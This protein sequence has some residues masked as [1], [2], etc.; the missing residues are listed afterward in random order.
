MALED[1]VYNPLS[2]TPLDKKVKVKKEADPLSSFAQDQLNQVIPTVSSIVNPVQEIAK[3]A[4]IE[5]PQSNVIQV[6]SPV[7]QSQWIPW[8]DFPSNNLMSMW[9]PWV[10]FDLTDD[11]EIQQIK[12]LPFENIL[13]DLEIYKT[14]PTYKDIIP[15]IQDESKLQPS[16]APLQTTVAWAWSVAWISQPDLATPF[17]VQK[18]ID[19]INK[20]DT[21]PTARDVQKQ[22]LSWL[23]E[24]NDFTS[25]AIWAGLYEWWKLLNKTASNFEYDFS[26]N[27]LLRFDKHIDDVMNGLLKGAISSLWSVAQ[28][29]WRIADKSWT[30][31]IIDEY[32]NKSS[33]SYETIIENNKKNIELADK[34]LELDWLELLK[35][36]GVQNIDSLSEPWKQEYKSLVNSYQKKIDDNMYNVW[37][38]LWRFAMTEEWQNTAS[39]VKDYINIW[40]TIFSFAAWWAIWGKAINGLLKWSLNT[41]SKILWLWLAWSSNIPLQLAEWFYP[42]WNSYDAVNTNKFDKNLNTND[43]VS[44]ITAISNFESVDAETQNFFLNKIN[45]I[46]KNNWYTWKEVNRDNIWDYAWDAFKSSEREYANAQTLALQYQSEWWL[47]RL[48]RQNEEKKFSNDNKSISQIEWKIKDIS[49]WDQSNQISDLQYHKSNRETNN[50]FRIF[51]SDKEINISNIIKYVS[52]SD[53]GAVDTARLI[54]QTWKEV[55]GIEWLSD[56]DKNTITKIATNKVNETLSE[57]DA[58]KNRA[59]KKASTE[60]V[61]LSWEEWEEWF[62]KIYDNEKANSSKLKEINN[63]LWW[64]STINS[65]NQIAQNYWDVWFIVNPVSYGI[66]KLEGKVWSAVFWS[67]VEFRTNQWYWASAIRQSEVLLSGLAEYIVGALLWKAV[68]KWKVKW[69]L[70]SEIKNNIDNLSAKNIIKNAWFEWLEEWVQNLSSTTLLWDSTTPLTTS[71]ILWDTLVSMWMWSLMSA[72]NSLQQYLYRQWIKEPN[73][74]SAKLSNENLTPDQINELLKTKEQK[75]QGSYTSVQKENVWW[76][77]IGKKQKVDLQT[78]IWQALDNP[79]SYTITINSKLANDNNTNYSFLKWE[80]G[81]YKEWNNTVIV[82]Q[83]NPDIKYNMNKN[84]KWNYVIQTIAQNEQDPIYTKEIALDDITTNKLDQWI[85]VSE[86]R[87]KWFDVISKFKSNPSIQNTEFDSYE[88]TW[89]EKSWRRWLIIKLNDEQKGLLWYDTIEWI[90]EP[91]LKWYKPEWSLTL[92]YEDRQQVDSGIEN[93][94]AEIWQSVAIYDKAQKIWYIMITDYN[95]NEWK[96]FNTTN[97]KSVEYVKKTFNEKMKNWHWWNAKN[98]FV[99]EDSQ[100]VIENWKWVKWYYDYTNKKIVLRK[101]ADYTTIIHEVAHAYLDMFVANDKSWINKFEQIKQW[102]NAGKEESKKYIKWFKEF[103]YESNSGNLWEDTKELHEAFARHFEWYTFVV[104]KKELWDKYPQ[105]ILWSLVQE[106][107]NFF[108]L[109]A[110][111]WARISKF[112]VQPLTA[113]VKEIF[114]DILLNKINKKTN[115]SVNDNTNNVV[116]TNKQEL[117]NFSKIEQKEHEVKQYISAMKKKYNKWRSYKFDYYSAWFIDN[118]Y[119]EKDNPIEFKLLNNILNL[120]QNNQSDKKKEDYLTKQERQKTYKSFYHA[121]ELWLD[122]NYRRW[123]EYYFWWKQISKEWGEVSLVWVYSQWDKYYNLYKFKTKNK[124]EESEDYVVIEFKRTKKDW[125][126]QNKNLT[127]YVIKKDNYNINKSDIIISNN[128]NLSLVDYEFE[129]GSLVKEPKNIKVKSYIN[130]AQVEDKLIT[131]QGMHFTYNDMSHR[132]TIKKIKWKTKETENYRIALDIDKN[133]WLYYIPLKNFDDDDNKSFQIIND[134]LKEWSEYQQYLLSKNEWTEKSDTT[135]N[136]EK[137]KEFVNDWIDYLNF[138]KE[139]RKIQK[140]VE[141]EMI[142]FQEE[143]KLSSDNKQYVPEDSLKSNPIFNGINVEFVKNMKKK[144]NDKQKI[145]ARMISKTDNSWNTKYTLKIDIPFLQEKFKE[146]SWIKPYQQEDGSSAEELPYNIF[147][148]FDNFLTF[149]LLHEYSHTFLPQFRWE[150]KWDYETRI[151]Y[152]ALNLIS[153]EYDSN[154]IYKYWTDNEQTK[155]DIWITDNKNIDSIQNTIDLISDNQH[156]DREAIEKVVEMAQ[157]EPWHDALKNNAIAMKHMIGNIFW[158]EKNVYDLFLLTYFNNL[159]VAWKLKSLDKAVISDNHKRINLWKLIIKSLWYRPIY[160]ADKI[161]D[162]LKL[163]PEWKDAIAQYADHFAIDEDIIHNSRERLA[164][165]MIDNNI[166]PMLFNDLY[167]IVS[168]IKEDLALTDF[169]KEDL[170]QISAVSQVINEAVGVT[171]EPWTKEYVTRYIWNKDEASGHYEKLLEMEQNISEYDKK[172]Q[173]AIINDLRVYQAYLLINDQAIDTNLKYGLLSMFDYKQYLEFLDWFTYTQRIYMNSVL[174]RYMKENE[175]KDNRVS[176]KEYLNSI[177]DKPWSNSYLSGIYDDL[178]LKKFS[179]RKQLLID[180]FS[181]FIQWDEWF[182]VLKDFFLQKTNPF[183]DA[184][185]ESLETLLLKEQIKYWK[186]KSQSNSLYNSIMNFYKS[187]NTGNENPTYE[188]LYYTTKSVLNSDWMKKFKNTMNMFIKAYE[189]NEAIWKEEIELYDDIQWTTN[190]ENML[191]YLLSNFLVERLPENTWYVWNKNV[192]KWAYNYNTTVSHNSYM[193]MET[194]VWNEI[195]KKS[196]YTFS[197]PLWEAPTTQYKNSNT[198]TFKSYWDKELNQEWQW[199]LAYT[200]PWITI[201]KDEWGTMYVNIDINDEWAFDIP[202]NNV[203]IFNAWMEAYFS[204]LEQNYSVNSYGNVKNRVLTNAIKHNAKFTKWDYELSDNFFQVSSNFNKKTEDIVNE[205]VSRTK[206]YIASL[207]VNG[208]IKSASGVYWSKSWIVSFHDW[209]S[210]DTINVDNMK[211]KIFWKQA[212]NILYTY[213]FINQQ[214]SDIQ[215]EAII[216]SINWVSKSKSS[217]LNWLL[218]NMTSGNNE[219]ELWLKAIEVLKYIKADSIVTI[220]TDKDWINLIDDWYTILNVINKLQNVE[221][222]DAVL[223]KSFYNQIAWILW[224]IKDKNTFSQLNYYLHWYFPDE[225]FKINENNKN[226]IANLKIKIEDFKSQIDVLNNRIISK[227]NKNK[228]EKESIKSMKSEIT[229][230]EKEIKDLQYTINNINNNKED[231]QNKEWTKFIQW[232]QDNFENI[233]NIAWILNSIWSSINTDVLDKIISSYTDIRSDLNIRSIDDTDTTRNTLY[234]KMSLWKKLWFN[235][236]DDTEFLNAVLWKNNILDSINDPTSFSTFTKS[237]EPWDKVLNIILNSIVFNNEFAQYKWYN[238]SWYKNAIRV[239]YSYLFWHW[240]NTLN[241]SVSFTDK[242]YNKDIIEDVD[243]FI[244]EAKELYK[245]NKIAARSLIWMIWFKWA[246]GWEKSTIDFTGLKNAIIDLLAK[247]QEDA[248]NSIVD[249]KN[250]NLIKFFGSLVKNFKN[251]NYVSN[252]T[253]LSNASKLANDYIKNNINQI[254]GSIELNEAQERAVDK[255]NTIINWMLDAKFWNDKKTKVKWKKQKNWKTDVVKPN[256]NINS[257]FLVIHWPANTW[258]TTLI[259][260]I[261]D[262]LPWGWKVSYFVWAKNNVTKN[263]LEKELEV[264]AT[265]VFDMLYSWTLKNKQVKVYTDETKKKEINTKKYKDKK[266]NIDYEKISENNTTNFTQKTTYQDWDWKISWKKL[267]DSEINVLIIDEAQGVDQDELELFKKLYKKNAIIVMLWDPMQPIV[268]NKNEYFNSL[269]KKED[270]NSDL[271]ETNFS[272]LDQINFDIDK[273]NL[274]IFLTNFFMRQTNFWKDVWTLKK[275]PILAWSEYSIENQDAIQFIPLNSVEEQQNISADIIAKATDKS[276]V[277]PTDAYLLTYKN[278]TRILMNDLIRAK[279]FWDN[280]PDVREWDIMMYLNSDKDWEKF[281]V[282]KRFIVDSKPVKM[283]DEEV[284]KNKPLSKLLDELENKEAKVYLYNGKPHIFVK[285]E[286]L[287]YWGL[288]NTDFPIIS[289]WYALTSD[290]ALWTRAWTVVVYNDFNEWLWGQDTIEKERVY[291]AITRTRLNGRLYIADA[292]WYVKYWIKWKKNELAIEDSIVTEFSVKENNI[293]LPMYVRWSIVDKMVQWFWYIIDG[294]D[295]LKDEKINLQKMFQTFIQEFSNT[296]PYDQSS[297]DQEVE[298]I[299]TTFKSFFAPESNI[300]NILSYDGITTTQV[301]DIINRYNKIVVDKYNDIK[302]ASIYN[303]RQ[304]QWE[305]SSDYL[306]IYDTDSKELKWSRI[307][308]NVWQDNDKYFLTKIE[309]I[310]PVQLDIFAK[311][312]ESIDE[313]LDLLLSAEDYVAIQY[314][315]KDKSNV[316]QKKINQYI[317]YLNRVLQDNRKKFKDTEEEQTRKLKENTEASKNL[318]SIVIMFKWQDNI[319]FNNL[320]RFSW[321]EDGIKN[322]I[323]FMNNLLVNAKTLE[324]QPKKAIV[325]DNKDNYFVKL[326]DKF[327][328]NN[329][330]DILIAEIYDILYSK[331]EVEWD[332]I[333]RNELY[334]SLND[335]LF[336][337]Y[338]IEWKNYSDIVVYALFKYQKLWGSADVVINSIFKKWDNKKRIYTTIAEKRNIRL[339]LKKN[340]EDI[341]ST[342]NMK[343]INSLDVIRQSKINA[344][345]TVQKLE[346]SNC[347]ALS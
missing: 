68:W 255:F 239:W 137:L 229:N 198:I 304:D 338:I 267:S 153:L 140:E 270:K 344:Q 236:D 204:F 332:K 150:T 249:G 46:N 285:S 99:E 222:S 40:W 88:Q 135:N 41:A 54:Q 112:K 25:D 306:D 250:Y 91:N 326:I 262:N 231:D 37:E 245:T 274:D 5:L 92:R 130:G 242:E 200:I 23:K 343:K 151:N 119:N 314:E 131:L 167:T 183:I 292:D 172:S 280:T 182:N 155:E 152:N 340:K 180:R 233:K 187:L 61:W 8:I 256:K 319:D 264:K 320:Y 224:L 98:Y 170:W 227:R 339:A 281:S 202:K 104:A 173:L 133:N 60:L 337:Q 76:T 124:S 32:Q 50:K 141:E 6:E 113:W 179:N 217:R 118:L 146:K 341:T 57:I 51:L 36:Y 27:E 58:I 169:V 208:L 195:K 29:A 336:N 89:S 345:I 1:Y 163:W 289:Y 107:T 83:W 24:V 316:L 342:L 189:T 321:D 78:Y 226:Q 148:N 18:D 147:D 26:D 35:K 115:D 93:I 307:Y 121:K 181:D 302:K 329:L 303:N 12:S 116:E 216:W 252:P 282:K 259:K 52:D 14:T 75:I 120:I 203:N 331:W 100:Q 186:N 311:R 246:W 312:T 210:E 42:Q 166:N 71:T 194:K 228:N 258:K 13:W 294:I 196:D 85:A 96:D 55:L 184:K 103:Q 223:F 214:F 105:T 265:T 127:S 323:E 145:A 86:I 219:Y 324:Q 111:Y 47:N 243:N 3:K 232:Y 84:E 192:L 205:Y 190:Q 122:K 138:W 77:N 317:K 199:K 347:N 330:D 288:N 64:S 315:W 248:I 117:I 293:H 251:N 185:N 168:E 16:L 335:I 273:D 207:N 322:K 310:A 129:N 230:L 20:T 221:W 74:D 287:N 87:K 301:N 63:A 283:S 240:V 212:W 39:I 175:S 126:F 144:W 333:F 22:I 225:L 73:A 263:V 171:T 38:E 149:V 79:D 247:R 298:D 305:F 237:N 313:N 4:N 19:N 177:H 271:K 300:P 81:F 44:L 253:E 254:D 284:R 136:I 45:T 213:W 268:W 72:N 234:T 82:N 220:N 17:S 31:T 2:G 30:D 70:W 328:D 277:D 161:Q 178:K 28:S 142:K 128:N 69:E 156:P 197:I 261:I 188:E 308:Q 95:I 269:I 275:V 49:W 65:L 90:L 7:L 132:K 257:Q 244:N 218:K 48:F 296:I 334:S 164:K 318:N 325:K 290:W 276:V 191:W 162:R 266:W 123:Q 56:A 174:Y 297:W 10:D 309:N 260:S 15:T 66:D 109:I 279:K 165:Y 154:E 143:N 125:S 235:M 278:E 53:R 160:I 209:S 134:Y 34:K 114:N 346:E 101:D 62:K 110:S 158:W 59:I 97:K 286:T 241:W 159:S 157:E 206:D 106:M 94:K 215:I 80:Y 295:D 11:D 299:H 21:Q 43:Q 9:V 272:I 201:T 139:A 327:K 176:F 193:N 102:Y 238:Q 33:K 291:T 211:T 108:K 67:E